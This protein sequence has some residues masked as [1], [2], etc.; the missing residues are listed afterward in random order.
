MAAFDARFLRSS[1]RCVAMVVVLLATCG[2]DTIATHAAPKSISLQTRVP[3][4]ASRLI[5]S[6][7]PPAP[8]AVELTFP[9]L[10]FDR[11]TVITAA[12]GT[13]RLFVGERGG[14]IYS[15]VNNPQT[16]EPDLLLDTEREVYGLVFHPEFA[17]N[18]LFYVFISE[19]KPKPS[20]TRIARFQANDEDPPR[21]DP[22]SEFIILEFPSDGHDGGCLRFGSDGYLYIGTGDGGG[23]N[24]QHNTGQYI[25][26]LLA[27]ILRIDVNRT[28]HG[29]PYAIPPDN[30]FV[31]FPAARPEVYAYGL[32]QVWL[33]SFDRLTG[34]LWATDVGQDLWEMIHIVRPG[35]NYGW[36]VTEGTQPFRPDRKVGPTPIIPPL[37]QYSHDIGRSITGGYVYRGTK[38][39]NLYGTYLYADYRTGKLWGL[40]SDGKNVTWNE[41]LADTA[42]GIAS[43]AEDH[44]GEL[45]LLT[46]E[47]GQIYTVVEA[48]PRPADVPK[49]PRRLSETGLFASVVDHV[50]APGVLPYSVN[51]PLWSDGA[52]KERFMALPGDSQIQFNDSGWRFPEGSVLVKT[53]SLELENG[54]PQSRRRLETRILMIQDRHWQGYVYKWN[55]EGTDAVLMARDARSETYQVNAANGTHDQTWYYPSRSDCILCHNG[56]FT[57]IGMRTVQL[58]REHDYGGTIANQIEVFDRLGLFTEPLPKPVAEL[59]RLVNPHDETATLEQRARS[60]LHANC[61]NCH[62]HKGG[63][64]SRFF[65]NQHLDLDKTMTVDVPPIHGDL[66]IA[67]ARLVA[68]GDPD[69]SII[70]QRMKRRGTGQMPQVG[71]L[72]VDQT[73]LELV[74]QWIVALGTAK[75]K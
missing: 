12:S 19:R 44:A 50:P 21:A 47:R 41:E 7:D 64:N 68:P 39:K 62:R 2:L 45:Y 16:R 69:R 14:R 51:S 15:F 8:Y 38:L 66:G 24:D 43:F 22:K 61:A 4:T 75:Q 52:H 58:N 56:S 20:R 9:H 71:T 18:R 28:E 36:S 17:T 67:N 29:R 54:N 55:D 40:R 65:I 34:D 30:P 27:S 73:G 72:A 37:F 53:F 10:K 59:D 42:L 63:G 23:A 26:D 13:D 57:L 33:M 6:P 3:W 70:L 5:G 74:R 35:A 11:P 48:P 60:Y 25:G 49:F 46:H 31:D 32:R 1:S